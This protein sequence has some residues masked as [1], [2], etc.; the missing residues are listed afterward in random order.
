M[1]PR[2]MRPI[3]LDVVYGKDTAALPGCVTIR[4]Y[5]PDTGQVAIEMNLPGEE[6]LRWASIFTRVSASVE[7]DLGL[8]QAVEL[9]EGDPADMEHAAGAQVDP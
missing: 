3:G 8:R 4:V 1:T 7:Q 2:T 5:F 9:P 6:Y